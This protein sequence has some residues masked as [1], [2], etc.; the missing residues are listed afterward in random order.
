MAVAVAVTPHHHSPL[1]TPHHYPLT[2]QHPSPCHSSPLFTPPLTTPDQASGA[3]E[4]SRL[5]LCAQRRVERLAMYEGS[6]LDEP[7]L[8]EGVR[9]TLVLSTKVRL[10]LPS[11]NVCNV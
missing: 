4:E 3:L 9:R 2:A 6:Q 1:P 5:A 7:A 11:C 8:Y 10:V